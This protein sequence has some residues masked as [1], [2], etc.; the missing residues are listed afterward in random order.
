MKRRRV[1][2]I[3]VLQPFRKPPVKGI[4]IPNGLRGQ[5][6]DVGKNEVIKIPG[7]NLMAGSDLAAEAVIGL[8]DIVGL[9]DGFPL[10]LGGAVHILPPDLLIPRLHGL[11]AVRTV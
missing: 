5:I 10:F 4:L 8:A 9:I 2:L 7:L 11:A 3:S 6:L 1:R